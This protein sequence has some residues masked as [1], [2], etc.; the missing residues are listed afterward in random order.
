MWGRHLRSIFARFKNNKLFF[1][2][3]H[4]ETNDEGIIEQ[5][6]I[7]KTKKIKNC[8][9]Y[10]ALLKSHEIIVDHEEREKIILKKINSVATSKQ[11]K[12]HLNP[13]LLEEV[14]NIVEDP[15]LLIV[16]F[17]KDYLKIHQEIII[18]TLEKN[19]R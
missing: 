2:F 4:W 7:I 19:Q 6:V 14:V 15:N 16:N 17:N 12:E 11:Y 1:K 13:K 18:L 3:N 8:A 9:E 5:D 10:L